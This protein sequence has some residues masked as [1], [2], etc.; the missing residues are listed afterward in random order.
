MISEITG[1]FNKKKR[2]EEYGGKHIDIVPA[3]EPDGDQSWMEF[4]NFTNDEKAY[5]TVYGLTKK[6]KEEQTRVHEKA[7]NE[8]LH[9]E[10]KDKF[11]KMEKQL[12]ENPESKGEKAAAG[13]K[14]IQRQGIEDFPSEY[15]INNG[16][17][18]YSI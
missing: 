11:E 17:F 5:S 12:K 3:V 9:K 8:E 18:D 15:L 14:E 10:E 4:K 6:E 13:E 16:F 1:L 7:V 2:E